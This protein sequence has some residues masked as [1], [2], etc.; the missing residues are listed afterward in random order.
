M[1]IPNTDISPLMYVQ[2][3]N[4]LGAVHSGTIVAVLPDMG[5]PKKQSLLITTM[6]PEGLTVMGCSED[7]LLQW[8]SEIAEIP[9]VH[10]FPE[11]YIEEDD[12]ELLEMAQAYIA[13]RHKL[14]VVPKED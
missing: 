13:S 2:M 6:F 10:E 11:V 1:T 4:G 12:E 7:I 14:T 9:E 5:D 8:W 3:S